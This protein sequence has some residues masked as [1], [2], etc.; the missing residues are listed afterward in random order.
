MSKR[1]AAAAEHLPQRSLLRLLGVMLLVIVPHLLRLPTWEAALVLAI[2][3]WRAAAALRHWRMPHPLIK[4]ALTLAVFAG[5][6][7]TY[8]RV[9]GQ[10]A[11][12]ALLVVMLS[13]KLTELRERRDVMVTVFLLYFLLV[14]HF[15][16]SQEI[17]T[18]AYLLISTITITAVLIDVHH[19]GEARPAR[20]VL[21]LAGTLVLQ[22]LPLMLLMFVLFPRL[23]GPL[24]T[25]PDDAGTSRS[26][27]GDT[28]SPGDISHLALSDEIAFR[29]RFIDPAPAEADRYW[30]GPLLTD[31]D[32][33]TWRASQRL[34]RAPVPEAQL[35]GPAFR[36]EITLEPTRQNWL[37]ALDLPVATQLPERTRLTAEYQLVATEP[38]RELRRYAVVSQPRYRLQ[39]QLPDALHD[40]ALA[41]P[42]RANPRAQALARQWRAAARNDMDVVRAA[43]TLF[44]NAPYAYTLA[45]PSLGRSDA[46]RI[47][48]FLFNTRS[49][50]CEHYAGAFTFLMRA[51]GIPARVV[52]GYAGG[53][54]NPFG[55]WYVL[56]QADAHAWSEVWVADQG[57]VRVDPT[58]AVSPD[59]VDR[60]LSEARAYRDNAPARLGE[61][62]WSALRYRLE[63][64]WDWID[65]R[66]NGMVLGYGTDQQREFLSRIGLGDW[67]SMLLAL[68]GSITLLLTVLGVALMRRAAPAPLDA[69]LQS[70][71]RGLR[72]L[73]KLGFQQRPDEGARD[74]VQRVLITRPDLAEP[75][76]RLL[77]AYLRVRYESDTAAMQE[78]EAAA[79]NITR[80]P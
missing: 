48:A 31:F 56:R 75:L 34:A 67:Q 53:Q 50:Y 66:W 23:P 15:L 18:I 71:Q 73:Q 44:H 32:G 19:D 79:R 8:G 4:V 40:A 5:V 49:G 2:S 3:I 9:W 41:L 64:S 57:W 59:R 26:G 61:L 39:T 17:W 10:N 16:Y 33:L 68:T 78:L 74:F 30:R 25:L 14:T 6:F 24:W 76:Q 43:L 21:R 28:M 63:S 29:V 45:P 72:P 47:D 37:F 69:A 22:S 12:V 80:P 46:D 35:Q 13:L 38:V 77:T 65:A 58:S 70:W 20:M 52:T 27:L 11:G 42:P 60:S 62:D 7:A 55:D 54:K 1:A 36:Y 51:A